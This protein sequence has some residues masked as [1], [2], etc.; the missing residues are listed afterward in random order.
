MTGRAL[1]LVALISAGAALGA[2]TTSN[3][4]M[5]AATVPGVAVATAPSAM[6][7]AGAGTPARLNSLEVQE[8]MAGNT[9]SGTTRSGRPYY[10]KF[11]RDGSLAYREGTNDFSAVGSW[12][13]TQDGML[14]SRFPSVNAGAES[15][16]ALY[17][18]PDGYSYQRAD[19]HPVGT[20]KVVPGG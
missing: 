10:A 20:F 1:S 15:C 19:G 3:E 7:V 17:R 2:C 6:S 4:P 16:Y 18:N 13:V 12:H 8:V 11:A 5:A 9:A 14:C